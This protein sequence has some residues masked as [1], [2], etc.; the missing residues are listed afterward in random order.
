MISDKRTKDPDQAR[1]QLLCKIAWLYYHEELTQAEIGDKLGI[2]RVTINRLIREA[3]ETG[4]VEI[5]IR[6]NLSTF[7]ALAQDVSQKFELRDAITIPPPEE[8]EDLQ[9][10]LAQAA[11]GVMEQRLQEGMT[12]GVGIGR[13]ISYIPDFFRPA[14]PVPCRFIG[15]T[16]GLDMHQRYFCHR[17]IHG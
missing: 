5:K 9:V 10:L 14:A 17:Y 4:V 15:L 16:G 2:S 11:A 13:T 1:F 12:V 8:G 6:T 7:F 3:R